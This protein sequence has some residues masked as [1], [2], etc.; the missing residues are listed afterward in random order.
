MDNFIT[1]RILALGD[2]NK[3]IIINSNL[4]SEVSIL[5]GNTLFIKMNNN[6]EHTIFIDGNTILNMFKENLLG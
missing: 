5:D 1:V 3:K 4:I 2:T 6:N